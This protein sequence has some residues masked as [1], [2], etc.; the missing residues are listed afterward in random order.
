MRETIRRRAPLVLLA[1]LTIA[2]LMIV[3][4]CKKEN[5]AEPNDSSSGSTP[6][7]SA[8][9][10]GGSGD[11]VVARVGNA[12]I[13]R[14][15]L[16]ERLLASYGSQ[17]LRTL[18]LEQAVKEEAEAAGVRVTEEELGRELRTMSLGYEDEDEF[19]RSMDEQLGM[20]RDEVREEAR[21]RLLLEKL[22]IRGVEVTP[23]E[24]DRYREEHRAEFEPSR[25]YQFARIVVLT[26]GQAAGLLSKLEEGEDFAE[27]ARTYSMD[28]FTAD[29]GGEVGWIES[30]DPFEAPGVL[31]ALDAMNVGEVTGPIPIDYGYEIVR[32]DAR[33]ETQIKSEEAIELE[34][35]RAIALGKA[36]SARD[37]EQ[38]LLSKYAAE[39]SDPLLR[40]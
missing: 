39:V 34:I 3:A 37:Q 28:E 17:T 18:M 40:P 19:Y 31:K 2:T 4:G 22:A 1:L 32:L 11:E 20:N 25:K 13:T 15:Q 35:R 36:P 21:Y 38:A 8:S 33:S 23:D 7:G 16:L 24:V 9:E 26:E 6:T 5:V 29:A 27:L 12:S 10:S 14:Q 30:G